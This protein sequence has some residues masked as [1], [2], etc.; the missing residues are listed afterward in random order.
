MLRCESVKLRWKIMEVCSS[1]E[2][3]GWI[4]IGVGVWRVSS[5]SFLNHM[6]H[7]GRMAQGMRLLWLP[8]YPTTVAPPPHLSHGGDRAAGTAAA[9][10]TQSP[11][12]ACGACRYRRPNLAR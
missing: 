5:I 11:S 9:A 8:S 2:G 10:R 3:V 1:G 7:M 12:D 6:G 4:V